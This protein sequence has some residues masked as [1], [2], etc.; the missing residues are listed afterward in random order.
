MATFL[1]ADTHFGHAGIIRLCNRPFADAQQMD[2]AMI[3]CWN[4]AVRKDD[5][6]IHLG[7]FA[8]RYPADKLP[9][10]FETLNGKKYLIKGNHDGKETLALPWQSVR[11]IAYA[12]IDSQ[13]LVLCHFAMRTWPRI[14]RGALML[15]GHS[16][17]R[18]PGNVQ[19]C[20]VG[21]D[22]MG[23]APVRLSTIKNYLATLPLMADP[24]AR[25]EIDPGPEGLKP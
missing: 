11:D 5:T 9:A 23:F 4:A 6:V 14:R 13:N 20:D 21:V 3:S 19:S 1:I 10:L 15:F 24:E 22:V 16:H 25:D 2:A 8:H 12:S 17:G 7:D 18:L